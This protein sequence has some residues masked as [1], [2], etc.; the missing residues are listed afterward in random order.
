MSATFLVE[1]SV[2]EPWIETSPNDPQGGSLR[3]TGST[4]CVSEDDGPWTIQFP[5]HTIQA[6]VPAMNNNTKVTSANVSLSQAGGYFTVTVT[7]K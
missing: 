3:L 4:M 2:G 7:I 1:A 6:I 5:E